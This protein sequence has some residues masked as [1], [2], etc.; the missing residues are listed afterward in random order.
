MWLLSRNLE[1]AGEGIEIQE[2]RASAK[3]LR[4][5]LGRG[6]IMEG[7]TGRGPK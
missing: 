4:W 2:G 6:Q 1:E 5:R 7:H 3:V